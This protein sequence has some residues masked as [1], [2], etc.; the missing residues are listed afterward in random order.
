MCRG[1]HFYELKLA[2]VLRITPN[3]VAPGEASDKDNHIF[4]FCSSDFPDRDS[5]C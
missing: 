4:Y 5:G 1:K 2:F 3:I